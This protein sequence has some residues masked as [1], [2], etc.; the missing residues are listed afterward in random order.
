METTGLELHQNGAFSKLKLRMNRTKTYYHGSKKLHT[1]Y[2]DATII[3]ASPISID[4]LQLPKVDVYSKI[5]PPPLNKYI[6][7]VPLYAIQPDGEINETSFNELCACLSQHA[8]PKLEILQFYDVPTNPFENANLDEIYKSDDD[9]ENNECISDDDD[10]DVSVEDDD[11]DEW[12]EE[13][14]D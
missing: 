7:P 12:T 6:Y 1:H 2:S 8:Q 4:A 14:I 9:D 5:L 3:L 11:D 13:I 10:E